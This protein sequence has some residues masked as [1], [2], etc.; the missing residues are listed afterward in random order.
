MPPLT[1][2]NEAIRARNVTASEVAA[3]L[4]CGHPYTTPAAIYDRLTIGAALTPNQ[5]MRIG[6]A[7]EGAVLRFAEDELGIKARANS[8]TYVHKRVRLAATP[9]AFL[10]T[11]MPWELVPSRALIEIKMSGR[12]EQWRDVPPHV[13]AQARAQMAVMDRDVVFIVV[14]AAMRLL[15]FE[16]H[17]DAQKEAL[18]LDRV[19]TFWEDHIEAGIRPE[20]E[21]AVPAMTFSFDAA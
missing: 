21:A 15:T 1:P 8:R 10:L 7:L 20:T 17:R 14:V 11:P 2:A 16:V 5:A 18:L 4:D 19:H 3:L 13:D 12:V 6:S 9:D